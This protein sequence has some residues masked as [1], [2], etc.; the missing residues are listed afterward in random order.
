M[1]SYSIFMWEAEM[2]RDNDIRT[3][4]HQIWEEEGRPDGMHDEHWK[5]AQ[6]ELDVPA[7]SSEAG[8]MLGGQT[9]D[10]EPA[11]NAGSVSGTPPDEK[12]S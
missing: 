3:R 5:R 10:A 7:S 12:D 9:R 8:G 1:N 2:D 11:V 6:D 4:A